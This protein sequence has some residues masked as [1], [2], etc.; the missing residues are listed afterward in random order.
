MCCTSR[1]LFIVC[2]IWASHST[3]IP[4]QSNQQSYTGVKS[5]AVT[6][7]PGPCN[8]LVS[9]FPTCHAI[10]HKFLHTLTQCSRVENQTPSFDQN[11][12]CPHSPAVTLQV[13]TL[14]LHLKT[15]HY[16]TAT[17]NENSSSHDGAPCNYYLSSAGG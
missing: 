10:K 9:L 15:F 3:K 4:E 11:K 12:V 16:L 8:I 13:L 2:K 14:K 1:N 17:N 7:G 5:G 6:E